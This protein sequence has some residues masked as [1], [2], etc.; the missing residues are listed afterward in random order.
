MKCIYCGDKVEY[1]VGGQSVCKKHIKFPR[2]DVPYTEEFDN[3]VKLVEA[4]K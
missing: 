3:Y 4:G 1:I 2:N